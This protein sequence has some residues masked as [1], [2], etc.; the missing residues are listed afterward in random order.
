L[1]RP[2]A[3]VDPQLLEALD[4]AKPTLERQNTSADG[5]AEK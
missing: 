3:I 1:V 4:V 5:V 2:L